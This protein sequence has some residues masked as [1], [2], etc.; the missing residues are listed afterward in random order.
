[1]Y[2]IFLPSC[3]LQEGRIVSGGEQQMLA[4]SMSLMAKPTDTHDEP[5]RSCSHN[6]GKLIEAIVDSNEA[7][8]DL[9]ANSSP[10]QSF[11]S[12]TGAMCWRTA[13][14]TTGTGQELYDNPEIKQRI[15]SL[16]PIR[17]HSYLL[18]ASALLRRTNSTL[19]SS[20]SSRLF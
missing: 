15:L 14:L 10:G 17:L 20:W 11:P 6:T 13:S 19:L 8:D 7:N 4:I 5:S 2:T 18:P 12:L 3:R 1:L 9:T 16:A